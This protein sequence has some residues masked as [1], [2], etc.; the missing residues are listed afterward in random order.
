M[1]GMADRGDHPRRTRRQSVSTHD[2]RTGI[3]WLDRQ[4]CLRLLADD[5]IGRLAV[6]DGGTPVIF[7]VNYGLDGGHIVLRTDPG[8]K[9]DDGP[10]ARACF[11]IDHFDRES[12]SGWSVVAVGRLEEITHYDSAHERVQALPVDPWAGGEKAHWMRLVPDR[13]T[14]RRLRP[15]AGQP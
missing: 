1:I 13:I 10:R 14:G 2:A 5:E 3:E 7:P 9:L 12:R 8:T 15:A 11:E 4:E 6:L